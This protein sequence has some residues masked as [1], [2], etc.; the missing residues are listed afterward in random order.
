M[1]PYKLLYIYVSW[2]LIHFTRQGN[3]NMQACLYT[4]LANYGFQKSPY[5][6]SFPAALCQLTIWLFPLFLHIFC[7]WIYKQLGGGRD[8][9]AQIGKWIFFYAPSVYET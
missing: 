1:L 2:N 7:K 8:K 5:V 3:K 9:I 4:N 6:F